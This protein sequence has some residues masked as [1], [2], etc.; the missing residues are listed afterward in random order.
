MR[1]V[2]GSRPFVQLRASRAVSRMFSNRQLQQD[3]R[4]VLSVQAG[5]LAH[6][7]RW[8]GLVHG[9]LHMGTWVSSTLRVWG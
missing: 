3:V 1:C 7:E 6:P 2:G 4:L 5:L 8:M 9:M